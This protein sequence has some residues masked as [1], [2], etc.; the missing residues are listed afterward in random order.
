MRFRQI[1]GAD[2]QIAIINARTNVENIDFQHRVIGTQQHRFV[3]N[4]LRAEASAHA[5]C[6]TC[7][8]GNA[9]NRKIDPSQIYHIWEPHEGAYA[10]ETRRF[11]RIRRTIAFW[12]SHACVPSVYNGGD[13][14]SPP[15][16][17]C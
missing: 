1:T 7:V 5:K 11:H 12:V 17:T 16:S 13:E 10:A 3:P 4:P 8:E 14:D 9:Y 6:S 2:G 15:D